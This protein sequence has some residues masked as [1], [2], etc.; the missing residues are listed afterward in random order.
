MTLIICT[1]IIKFYKNKLFSCLALLVFTIFF[2]SYSFLKSSTDLHIISKKEFE[3]SINNN[4]F[5]KSMSDTTT[6]KNLCRY[7]LNAIKYAQDEANK[8]YGSTF[9]T[10]RY[11]SNFKGSV[12]VVGAG[13]KSGTKKS[14]QGKCLL[15]DFNKDFKHLIEEIKQ[16]KDLQ[17]KQNSKKLVTRLYNLEE[18]L[19]LYKRAF[20]LRNQDI[21][22][23]YFTIDID[24]TVQPDMVGSITSESDMSKIPD[25]RFDHIEFENVPCN[26]FLNP[27]LYK[28]LERIT[29]P[30]G[31][32]SLSVNNSCRRLIVPIIQRTKFGPSYLKELARK[33]VTLLGM[34]PTYHRINIIVTNH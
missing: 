31:T 18:K 13:K 33:Y 15:V 22:E 20:I 30:G 7:E 1:K 27:T 21:L 2:T 5:F 8:N 19:E 17:K 29:K 25:N 16:L 10:G 26:V 9:D 3:T 14:N 11:I 23:R 32:I 34:H 28:I 24:K 12:L 6:D 4:S